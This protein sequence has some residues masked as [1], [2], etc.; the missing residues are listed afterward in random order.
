MKKY[1]AVLLPAIMLVAGM[2]VK[3]Y[4]ADNDSF[5]ITA[6]VS[7]SLNILCKKADDTTAYGTWAT[8]TKAVS[9]ATPMLLTEVVKIINTSTVAI[10]LD[11]TAA[12]SAN[13]H[14]ATVAEANGYVL[15]LKLYAA[16]PADNATLAAALVGSTAV[17]TGTQFGSI[18]T[19]STNAFL[20]AE[21][22]TPSSSVSG[23]GQSLGVTITA[24]IK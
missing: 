24:T 7:S 18:D 3:A 21:F 5:T 23:L 20:Y 10:N 15:K 19:E 1:I 13:W 11:G 2:G 8:G 22:T 17:V 12:N 6:A 4:A 16:A 9:T 14:A